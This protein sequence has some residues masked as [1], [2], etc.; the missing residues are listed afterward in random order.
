MKRTLSII[1]LVIVV[2]VGYYFLKEDKPIIK[3]EPLKTYRNNRDNFS[4]SYP[5]ILTASTTDNVVILHHDISYQNS[6]ACDMMGDN[7]TYD[8]LT[9]FEMTV[10]IVNNKLTDTVKKMSPYIPQENYVN[11]ELITSPGFIDEYKIGTLS[12]FAI[13]EGAEGCGQTTYYF[14]IE[15]QKTLII[16]N[17]SIQILSGVISK[18]KMDQVLA[19]PGVISKTKNHEIFEDIVRSLKI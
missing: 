5:K 13:Y 2:S 17:A 18:E 4:F 3:S 14:P 9:D 16:T 7:K 11:D 8:K 1:A 10:Q 19:V 15:K 12:G 6:G